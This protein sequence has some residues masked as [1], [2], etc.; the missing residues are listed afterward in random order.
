MYWLAAAA[1]AI[2]FILT[3]VSFLQLCSEECAEG[4]NYLFLGTR[5]EVFGFL[6]FATAG[7]LHYLHRTQPKLKDIE[8]LLFCMG[9]GS[10]IMFIAIQKFMIGHW[11]PVC[12]GIAACIG[13]GTVAL[14]AEELLFIKE[15]IQQ[16]NRG[17]LMKAFK[18][19]LTSTSVMILGFIIAFF[20]V[21]KHDAIGAMEQSVKENL[22]FGKNDSPIEVYLFTDWACPA[23]R[24]LEP[25]IKAMSKDIMKQGRLIFVDVVV[26]PETLNYMPYHLAFLIQNKDRYFELRDMLTHISEKTGSPTEEEIAGASA[27]MGVTYKELNYSDVAMG[28][29]YFKALSEKF[30]IKATPTM[31]IINKDTKK[32]KKLVGNGEIIPENVMQSIEAI[33]KS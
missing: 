15:V 23:C 3:M 8:L 12:L 1:I 7:V 22:A 9:F 30:T 10:E 24:K 21:T 19:G 26:H 25:E 17:K 13:V 29:K 31:V 6:F 11:C 27:K 18:R 28:I 5:F 33:K 16:G 4:H 2:G 32:G 14:A 20:G